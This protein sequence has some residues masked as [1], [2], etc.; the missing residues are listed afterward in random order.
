MDATEEAL[1]IVRVRAWLRSGRAR[2]IRCRA[3]LS[4]SDVARVLGTTYSQVC[5]WE[6]GKAVPVRGAV[7]RLAELYGKL[8]EIAEAGVLAEAKVAAE[9]KA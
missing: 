1:T 2:E 3:G 8:E 9:V 4:Q 6:T 5:R 7:L